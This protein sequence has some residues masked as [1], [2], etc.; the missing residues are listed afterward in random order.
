[1]WVQFL[2]LLAAGMRPPSVHECI[3]GVAWKVY[4][5]IAITQVLQTTFY[6]K[7]KIVLSNIG[8]VQSRVPIT[9]YTS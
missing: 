8:S 2:G 1:M 6:F 5:H 3:Y 7:F 4:P 9:R